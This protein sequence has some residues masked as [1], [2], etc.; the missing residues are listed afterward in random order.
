MPS[1][2]VAC[3]PN[4]K[5]EVVCRQCHG[6]ISC[7]YFCFILPVTQLL[8]DTWAD[9]ELWL[10]LGIRDRR[11]EEKCVF[12]FYIIRYPTTAQATHGIVLPMRLLV[13]RYLWLPIGMLQHIPMCCTE[14]KFKHPIAPS[15]AYCESSCIKQAYILR[16]L[17]P[18]LT[19]IVFICGICHS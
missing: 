3:Y 4:I 1:L 5:S 18:V 9:V 10:Q 15:T 8:T 19:N 7:E 2:P 11:L 12:I 17:G 14:P 13:H 6:H 16:H